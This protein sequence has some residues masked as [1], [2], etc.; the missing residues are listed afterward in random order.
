MAQSTTGSI[1]GTVPPGTVMV[2][3]GSTGITRTVTAGADGRYN[4]GNLP[5]GDYK[6]EARGL[7]TRDATVTVG[8]GTDMSFSKLETV[9]VTGTRTASI[10]VSQVDT[11]T[12]FT[13]DTLSKIAVG[14]SINQV[15]M[16]A[17]GV[18]NSNSYNVPSATSS[19][20]NPLG[21]AGMAN[22]GSFGG[23]AASENAFYINGFPV[24]N[25]LTNMG[26]TT[27]PF[28]SIGQ[29]QVLTGGYGAEYGRSTGGVMSIIT[30]RGTN[31]WKGGGYAILTPDALRSTPKDILYPN[32]G[33]WNQANHYNNA[34]G[35]NPLNWTDG[36]L[37]QLRGQNT[38][39]TYTYGAYAGGPIIRDRL[40]IFA[41][42]EQTHQDVDGVRQTRV[43][44]LSSASTAA[45][46]WSESNNTYPRATVKVDWNI[47]DNHLL[48]LTG[49]Q[50]NAKEEYAYYGFNYNTLAR[51][52][53]KYNGD[54]VLSDTSRLYVA[55]YSGNI[56]DNL[57][58]SALVG[59]QKIKHNPDPL[60]GFDASKNFIT[61][62]ST[63][64][65]G[66]F[67]S[68]TN[69]QPIATVT[70]PSVDK[71]TGYRLDLT[72]ILGKHEMRVGYDHFKADS[73]IGSRN[74]GPNAVRWIYGLT[75]NPTDAI[76]A[77][78]GIGSPASAGGVYGS[79]GY[80][81]DQYFLSSGGAVSTVQAAWYLEDRWQVAD[82]LLLSLGFR[83][84]SFTN[85][86]G[87]HKPYV[88]QKGNKAPRLG[89]VWDVNGNSTL[90][91]FG[92]VGRYFLALPNNVAIRGANAS[93]N[94]DKYYTYTG[95]AADGTPTGLTQI[96]PAAGASGTCPAGTVGAGST[97]SNLECGNAPDPATVAIVNLKPHYQDEFIFG[98]E[99]SLTKQWSWG[100]KITY[101]DLKSAIDDTCPSEC[102]IFNPGEA[103]TFKAPDGNGGY[104]YTSYTKE[105]L[106]FPKLKRKYVAV[107]L[108][109]EYQGP[110]L[111]GKI[112]Y[113]WSRN[114][115]NAEGQL[116]STLDTGNGGQQ[117]VSVTSD[118]D[119]PELM[120]GTNGPLPN[121]RSHQIKMFGSYKVTDEWRVGGSAII[122]SGRPRSCT[123]WYPYAKDGI[124]NSA[125]YYHYCGVPGAQTSV[126]TPVA[127]DPGYAFSPRG[128]LGTTPWIK[129]FNVSVS[130]TPSQFKGLT[131]TADVL[132]VFDAQTPTTYYDASAN[133]GSRAMANARF[134]QVLYYTDPR[135]VRL[136]GRYDF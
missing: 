83:N 135:T 63:T 134:G 55:K 109:T 11:R 25:P 33:K 96:V 37:Y 77:S 38:N 23:S 61:I 68:I 78:H 133:T 92:N 79:Q 12:V 22:I 101:R 18:I 84:D 81:V 57:S 7:G 110:R 9:T 75:A 107:D 51:N 1:Y 31:E 124:Y 130:F 54:H 32:T 34:T 87:D 102:R 88:E 20:N 127:T 52:N 94:S 93:L 21:R 113:T 128:Q 90:K 115:G 116:N 17:P 129:T 26:A 29:V 65:P 39:S 73:Q 71:T 103:A 62:G 85:Y 19:N 123:S 80:Y 98:M 86:N 105:Q 43:G 36:T 69:P 41:N 47:T 72:Y 99:Q 49:V 8:G 131:L 58:V 64:V 48:E 59:Q 104:T 132:N 67:A 120:E 15:A 111:Y 50:D 60:T 95:I 4:I 46:G 3:T 106:G 122:Q 66:A 82:R 5:G 14:Q 108:F 118:W 76:D 30:K 42:V 74:S 114:Y 136:T 97:S 117:D 35:N 28:N 2:V 91:V 53:T 89:A 125:I 45:Q 119:L 70:D 6:V 16:L 40:F 121:N 24:T 44:S 56:T 13:A 112:E 10:D 27:L 126:N 100:A